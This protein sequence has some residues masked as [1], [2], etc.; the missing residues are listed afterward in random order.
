MRLGYPF[1][2][3]EAERDKVAFTQNPHAHIDYL[4]PNPQICVI[5]PVSAYAPHELR[6]P[7]FT[8][9]QNLDFIN[10]HESWHCRDTKNSFIGL[11]P[12]ELAKIDLTKPENAIGS[13]QA[14]QMYAIANK[15]ES[16]ADVGALGDMIRKGADPKIID[17]AIAWRQ[18][19]DDPTHMTIGSLEALKQ[20]INE[21][22]PDKFRKLD[23][24]QARALY[25]G[26]VDGAGMTPGTVEKVITYMS[27]TQEIRDTIRESAKTDPE[28]QKALDTIKPYQMPPAK[29]SPE[30]LAAQIP[31]V[32][33]LTPDE[34]KVFDQLRQYNA[35]E[36]L[37]DRA[38]R[39]A[40]KIT[41]ATLTRA[42]GEMQEDL[43]KKLDKDP[44]NPFL[45]AQATKLQQSYVHVVQELDYVGANA[46]RGVD[47]YKKEPA[48]KDMA[49][50]TEDAPQQ[51]KTEL[52]ESAPATAGGVKARRPT[53]GM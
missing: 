40:G 38:F 52:S 25:N 16:L 42:Y 18:Q 8:Q 36:M 31:V 39:D 34:Q 1:R 45:Q 29:D 35:E 13:P 41:P 24:E 23:E 44:D 7:G 3:G 6:V 14:L 21:M 26:V 30:A 37:Q 49:P 50:K 43:R 15:Q 32:K 9:Q 10:G 4:N 51:K 46:K 53:M 33:P 19:M 2:Y 48:L 17:N 20:K 12:A 47:I 22:G 28:W 5:V 27:G 11:D